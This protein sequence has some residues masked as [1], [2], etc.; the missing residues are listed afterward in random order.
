[1]RTTTR[2]KTTTPGRTEEEGLH[3]DPEDARNLADAVRRID[4]GM[5]AIVESGLNRRALVI[6]LHDSTGVG[7]RDINAV[8]NGLE[9][10][11]DQYLEQGEGT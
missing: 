9:S 5:L 7:K 4:Q 1:M 8:L 2:T 6:L 3:L 10:L 11:A